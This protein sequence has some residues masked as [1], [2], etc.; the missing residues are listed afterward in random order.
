M[1]QV[2]AMGEYAYG[3]SKH[4]VR[5]IVEMESLSVLI[6]FVF[7]IKELHQK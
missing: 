7:T 5:V 3:T 6:A 1:Q 2:G 4:R